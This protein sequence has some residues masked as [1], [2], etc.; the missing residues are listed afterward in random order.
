MLL[1]GTEENVRFVRAVEAQGCRA[2]M[3]R[4]PI[5]GTWR[6][7]WNGLRR[8]LARQ[9][10]LG[11]LFE[12]PCTALSLA[13][14]QLPRE[15]D[16]RRELLSISG[17]ARAM[18][19][20]DEYGIPF[21]CCYPSAVADRLSPEFSSIARDRHVVDLDQCQ[22]GS[23]WRKRT[24]VFAS[25]INYWDFAKLDQRCRYRRSICSR[26]G[27]RHFQLQ[28][29]LPSGVPVTTIAKQWPPQLARAIASTLLKPARSFFQSM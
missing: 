15:D 13:R 27:Q 7:K 9:E 1:I 3:Y 5:F 4:D 11:V 8:A 24:R 12:P 10:V 29:R 14:H 18:D 25:G 19:L 17:A 28:G 26:T 16:M 22:F 2:T 6:Q 23:P 21:I 20:L